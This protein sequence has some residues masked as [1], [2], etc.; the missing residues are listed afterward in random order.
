MLGTY[1][2]TIHLD[3]DGYHPYSW[4]VNASHVCDAEAVRLCAMRPL[5]GK[6]GGSWPF[7]KHPGWTREW[8]QSPAFVL[9]YRYSR[10]A[11]RGTDGGNND[12]SGHHW[13]ASAALWKLH[14]EAGI[15]R[16][17][18][19]SETRGRPACW[20]FAFNPAGL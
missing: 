11:P 13:A 1:R 5:T 14:C 15:G 2:C 12:D 7:Q 4:S 20:R 8:D 18:L 17:L 3:R 19:F 10:R 16:T 6:R 9:A